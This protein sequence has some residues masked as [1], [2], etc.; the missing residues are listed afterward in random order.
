VFGPVEPS[1][2]QIERPRC[3]RC[4]A[5]MM[6]ARIEPG[7]A[8]SVLRTFECPTCERVLLAEDDSI[9][10]HMAWL[11]SSELRPPE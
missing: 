1:L 2:I 4:Q 10:S 5:Y 9:R 3:R 7:P 11:N 8:G 6:L